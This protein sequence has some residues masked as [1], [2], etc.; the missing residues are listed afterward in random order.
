MHD[1]TRSLPARTAAALQG[2][3]PQSHDSRSL[4]NQH[5]ASNSQVLD[6]KLE[7]MISSTSA[8]A[9]FQVPFKLSWLYDSEQNVTQDTLQELDSSFK[10]ILRFQEYTRTCEEQDRQGRLDRLKAPRSR[11]SSPIA[12]NLDS[13]TDSTLGPNQNRRNKNLYLSG[14]EFPGEPL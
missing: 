14:R 3:G 1:I 12:N 5:F 11:S 9:Q 2:L 10:A 13:L 7:K 6:D 8:P 4:I